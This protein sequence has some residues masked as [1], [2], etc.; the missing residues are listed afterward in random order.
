MNTLDDIICLTPDADDELRAWNSDSAQ[1]LES[2]PPIMIPGIADDGSLYPV[3][4]IRAHLEGRYHL[5]L[6]VFVFDNDQLL[7][8]KRADEKYHCGGQWANTCC[9]HPHMDENIQAAAARRL[10]EELGFTIPVKETRIVEYSADVGG[11]LWE[12]E[13][14]HMFRADAPKDQVRINPNPEEVS[15]TRWVTAEELKGDIRNDPG[16]FTPWFKIYMNRF[17]DFEF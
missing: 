9:T 5:A 11:G 2:D 15:E 12:H 17:P 16:S 13:R 8:Q 7:I 14:V 10:K 4:K 1:I 3:E 6:S